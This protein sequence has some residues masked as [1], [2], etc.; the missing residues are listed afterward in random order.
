MT[1]SL[2]LLDIEEGNMNQDAIKQGL[3][4]YPVNQVNNYVAYL[5]RLEFEKDKNGNLKNPWMKQRSD[6]F[7]IHIFKVVSDDGL[8][9]D[10]DDITLQ[11]TGVSY[12]YQAYK[13]KMLLAYP[14]SIID[15]S[16]VY[17]DDTFQFQKQSGKVQ[18]THTIGNPF[19]RD[20]TAIIGAYCVIKNH[21]GEFLTLLSKKDIDKHRRVAKTDYIWK[22]W[23][24]EMAMKTIM[25]KACKQHFKDVFSNI[26][27]MDNQSYDLEKLADT[28]TQE[29]AEDFR[30]I[31]K[32]TG[33]DE[34][35][36][37]EYADAKS[38]ETI[39]PEMYAKCKTMLDA[40]VDATKAKNEAAA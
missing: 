5:H 29:Q 15:V 8:V 40:K 25:K 19:N 10:G 37:L 23:P 20:E 27:A 16:L 6:D 12:N 34:K 11:K 9:F 14:E 17:K 2:R 26:E 38:I 22:N 18:Y 28:I 1:R 35:R 36:F 32:D 4:K 7:L 3:K 39:R 24:A 30:K 21:R 13:N 33:A 31:I